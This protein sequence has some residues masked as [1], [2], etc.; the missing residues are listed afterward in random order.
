MTRPVTHCATIACIADEKPWFAPG[1]VNSLQGTVCVPRPRERL[2]TLTKGGKR[3]DTERLFHAE[4]G[5]EI[6]FLHE[7]VM[8][9]RAPAD[10][11]GTGGRRGR[12]AAPAVI[13]R[14]LGGAG[15]SAKTCHCCE[16]CDDLRAK[17]RRLMGD[18]N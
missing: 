8:G 3:I 11:A 15:M 1:H 6:Q 2:W 10:L 13:D 17:V 4:D 5:V 14:R 18:S 7:G 12:G 16:G 9:V